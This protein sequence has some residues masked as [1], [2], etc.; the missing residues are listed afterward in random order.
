[1][2]PLVTET[3]RD[4]FLRKVAVKSLAQTQEGALGL[5]AF[6]KEDKLPADLKLTAASELHAV[7]WPKIR[8]EAE[9]VLAPPQG[10]NAQPLPGIGELVKMK[11]NAANGEKIFYREQSMCSKC[12]RVKDRG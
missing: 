7:H 2:L 9:K 12:H 1:L 6:A 10:Q 11:G 3:Q 8:D 4:I 5:L